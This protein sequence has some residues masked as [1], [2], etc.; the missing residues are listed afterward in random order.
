MGGLVQVRAGLL[1][2]ADVLTS[3]VKGN[4]VL[5]RVSGPFKKTFLHRKADFEY[6]FMRYNKIYEQ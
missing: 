1:D 2:S 6:D 5:V 4:L 3:D